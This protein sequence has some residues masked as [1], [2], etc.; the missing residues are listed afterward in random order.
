MG[1]H[2][3]QFFSTFNYTKINHYR[4]IALINALLIELGSEKHHTTSA[5]Q[6]SGFSKKEMPTP[7]SKLAIKFL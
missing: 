3:I 7:F 2:L 5:W 6:N 1:L 4:R